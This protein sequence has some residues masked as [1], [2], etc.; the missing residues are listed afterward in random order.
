MGKSELLIQMMTY[1]QFMKKCIRSFE[2]T[3]DNL[4]KVKI[5]IPRPRNCSFICMP[6]M[7]CVCAFVHGIESFSHSTQMALFKL[8]NSYKILQ[9]RIKYNVKTEPPKKVEDQ[10]PFKEMRIISGLAVLIF[11]SCIPISII[12]RESITS[13]MAR[14]V[15]TRCVHASLPI[16]QLY[17]M[18]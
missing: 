13:V 18:Q 3:F 6:S 17:T 8:C 7:Y 15:D 1:T 12:S 2:K 11:L 4:Q 5:P 14:Q 10:C 9:R 16:K